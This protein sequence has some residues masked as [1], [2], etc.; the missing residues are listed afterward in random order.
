MHHPCD[1]ALGE[2]KDFVIAQAEVYQAVLARFNE[3]KIDIPGS[4]TIVRLMNNP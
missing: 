1:Q 4:G 3:K 2:C